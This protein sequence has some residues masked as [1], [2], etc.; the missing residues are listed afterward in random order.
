MFGIASAVDVVSL[1]P[2]AKAGREGAAGAAAIDF[3]VAADVLA[4][5]AGFAAGAA[6]GA[7]GAAAGGSIGTVTV[8][9]SADAPEINAANAVHAIT[10]PAFNPAGFVTAFS[11]DE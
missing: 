3:D 9:S 8:I 6:A 4:I 2:P 7:A 5:G 10:Q 1:L 11:P